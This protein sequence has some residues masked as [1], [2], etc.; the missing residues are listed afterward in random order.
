MEISRV[1]VCQ[2]REEEEIRGRN[3]EEQSEWPKGP[4]AVTAHFQCCVCGSVVN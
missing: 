1:R 3:K 2:V 4:A